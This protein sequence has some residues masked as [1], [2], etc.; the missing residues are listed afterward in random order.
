MA[1][2]TRTSGALQTREAL[3]DAG[4][5]LAEEHGLA[6]ASVNM[7]VARAGV[8]KGTFYVHFKDRAAFVDA[9]HARFH[10]RVQAAVDQAVAGLPPGARRLSRASEAY[11]DVSL[12]NRGVKALSLEA[13]SDPAVQGS[14]AVRRERLT[15]AG[16]ADLKAMGWDD[17]EAAAQLLAAMTR[18]ISV[19]EFDAGH[20]LPAPRRALK[21]FLGT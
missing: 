15:A 7:V 11:L 12:A 5:A 13:R 10:A 16:V 18:E 1:E 8:A 19:L 21:R 20:R 3:L 17:A 6:G 14:M 9:M 2:G 4:A